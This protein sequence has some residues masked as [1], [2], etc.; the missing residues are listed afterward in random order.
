MFLSVSCLLK[1]FQPAFTFTLP[2]GVIA[3][4]TND[5][6]GLNLITELII[7]YALPHRPIAMMMFKTWGSDAMDQ[8]LSFTS[9]LKIGHY[10]KIPHRPM[11]FCL[12][13][14]TVVSSTVQLGVQ[15]WMFSHIE[16]LCSFS[17][18]HDFICPTTNTFGS[19]SIIV[20]PHSRWSFSHLLM[21]SQWG[22]IGPRYIF[23]H[24]H[25]YNNLLF[26]LVGAVA[27][28]IQWACHKTFKLTFLKY[29]NFPIIFSALDTI[30][31]AT[32]FNIVPWVLICFLFNYVIRRR[33][34]FW[35]LKYNCRWLS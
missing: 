24:G 23:S 17:Q 16:D 31:P 8:A 22:V 26:F 7:G 14:G 3:A 15:T 10:M 6:V 11:F 18:E 2:N 34:I 33:H 21:Y 29:V 20:G 4:M 19:A 30:P 12:V 5:F 27:P 9:F 32:P 28:L 13:I 1:F 35:W 25:L